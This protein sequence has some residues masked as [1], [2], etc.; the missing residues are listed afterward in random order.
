ME[1]MGGFSAWTD[2]W[3]EVFQTSS[4]MPL[5]EFQTRNSWRLESYQAG[6]GRD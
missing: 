4:L 5:M 1:R 2:C 3:S 6:S